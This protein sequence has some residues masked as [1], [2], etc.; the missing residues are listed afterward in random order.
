M[1][2]GEFCINALANIP[3][4]YSFPFGYSVDVYKRQASNNVNRQCKESIEAAVREHFDG[5]YLSHDAAKGVIAVSYT[6]LDP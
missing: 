4:A 6:H 5:M 3:A 1:K 2:E